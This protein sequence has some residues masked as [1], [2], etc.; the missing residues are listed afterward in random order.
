MELERSGTCELGV[1]RLGGRT[2]RGGGGVPS[3]MSA[4][5]MGEGV[6]GNADLCGQE[7]KG[8]RGQFGRPF[9]PPTYLT[10]LT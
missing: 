3:M 1:N 5:E 2:L 10:Y 9:S 4:L 7:G 8:G 6:L